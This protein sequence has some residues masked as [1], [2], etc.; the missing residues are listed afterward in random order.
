MEYSDEHFHS[1]LGK[2]TLRTITNAKV[3]ENGIYKNSFTLTKTRVGKLYVEMN[4]DL[5]KKAAGELISKVKG[6]KNDLIEIKEEVSLNGAY[7]RGI[8]RSTVVA[9][10][11]TKAN[12]VNI[13]Y[14]NAPYSIG[15]IECNEITKGEKWM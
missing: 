4:L 15:H 7:S 14:G 9:L 13:A 5:G 1:N 10:D 12:I 11:E 6:T 3:E 8:A 2:I